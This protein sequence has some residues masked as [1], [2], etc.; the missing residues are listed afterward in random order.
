M[1][2]T[3]SESL[4]TLA[5]TSFTITYS[6]LSISYPEPVDLAAHLLSDAV[7]VNRVTC[8]E[9]VIMLH[10]SSIHGTEHSW[11]ANMDIAREH[12]QVEYKNYM[13]DG[14]TKFAEHEKQI[15]TEEFHIM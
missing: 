10:Q 4:S 2:T 15:C 3:I 14:A 5:P 13:Q 9:L 11:K 1:C 12:L 7:Q 6:P 8:N